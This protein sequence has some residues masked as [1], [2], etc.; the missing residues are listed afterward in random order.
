MSQN[1]RFKIIDSLR[2]ECC[3]LLLVFSWI[4]Q[5]L[6]CKY[7]DERWKNALFGRSPLFLV[8]V[9]F[10]FRFCNVSHGQK[11]VDEEK[12]GE[13]IVKKNL[14]D[15]G[16]TKIAGPH[17]VFTDSHGILLTFSDRAS[18]FPP[19]IHSSLAWWLLF[20]PCFYKQHPLKAIL[21]A[22]RC[23]LRFSHFLL[24]SRDPIHLSWAMW[25][26]TVIS[27]NSSSLTPNNPTNPNNPN[28]E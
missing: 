22:W 13:K 16:K 25:F 14:Q 11:L 6:F 4:S 18:L 7:F 10:Q 15:C 3:Y 19:Q 23:C 2:A 12:N 26:S 27:H 9:V 20:E 28:G 8:L 5:Y 21:S 17:A 24:S 1:H